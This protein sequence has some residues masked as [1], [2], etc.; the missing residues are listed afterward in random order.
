MV[1]LTV[2]LGERPLAKVILTYTG[3]FPPTSTSPRTV[4]ITALADSGADVTVVASN[5]WPEGWPTTTL[6]VGVTGVGGSVP[7]KRL[8]DEI[9]MSLV[10]R[11]GTLEGPHLLRPLVG[12]IE[13]SVLGR[14]LLTALGVR[15]TNL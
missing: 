1:A 3:Y 2:E 7:T 15:I 8:V 9:E 13:G 6:S 4:L 10:N 14:D 12:L 5:V 11:H